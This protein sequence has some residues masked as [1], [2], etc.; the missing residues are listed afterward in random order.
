MTQTF[1]TIFAEEDRDVLQE[2]PKRMHQW[3]DKV[4]LR[5]Y[6]AKGKSMSV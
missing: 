6:P 1:W 5:L 4:L 3:S 2:D